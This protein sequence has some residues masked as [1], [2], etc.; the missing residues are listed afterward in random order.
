LICINNGNYKEMEIK[1]FRPPA[2]CSGW[3]NR[4][5]PGGGTSMDHG[6]IKKE[7]VEA[8]MDSPL[9][10]TIPLQ[11]RLALVKQEKRQPSSTNL[12]ELFLNWVKTGYLAFK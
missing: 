11:M 6:R 8:W 7:M 12:R 10:F 3:L 4:R 9:Y 1:R 2:S 5:N